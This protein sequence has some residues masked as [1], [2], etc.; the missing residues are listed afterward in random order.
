M[1]VNLTEVV[2]EY[3]ILKNVKSELK[4]GKKNI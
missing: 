2:V 1:Q 4:I 3:G